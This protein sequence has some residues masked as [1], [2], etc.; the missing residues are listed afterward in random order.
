MRHKVRYKLPL[1]QLHFKGGNGNIQ[2]LRF[3]VQDNLTI[4]LSLSTKGNKY[5]KNNPP[6]RAKAFITHYSLINYKKKHPHLT[7]LEPKKHIAH[8]AQRSQKIVLFIV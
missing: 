1:L 5:I 6:F 3:M 7:S 8:T 2:V 4:Q